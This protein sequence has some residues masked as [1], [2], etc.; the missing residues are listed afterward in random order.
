MF[1]KENDSEINP[2]L[3]LELCFLP[4]ISV[5]NKQISISSQKSWI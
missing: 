5:S 3:L 2:L 1:S 4:F